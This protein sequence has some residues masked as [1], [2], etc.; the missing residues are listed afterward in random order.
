MRSLQFAPLTNVVADGATD[1]ADLEKHE[2]AY[3]DSDDAFQTAWQPSAQEA[4]WIADGAAIMVAFSVDK[5]GLPR[6][7][8]VAVLHGTWKSYQPES[9]SIARGKTVEEPSVNGRGHRDDLGGQREGVTPAPA[10]EE[11]K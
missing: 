11:T 7:M 10:I 4:A 3:G 2:L 1:L 9:P 8:M 6:R 5:E